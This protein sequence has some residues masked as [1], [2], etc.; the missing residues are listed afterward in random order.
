[1]KT[2]PRKPTPKPDGQVATIS[3]A[4]KALKV[5]RR[6]ISEGDRERLTASVRA[7]WKAAD[8]EIWERGVGSIQKRRAFMLAATMISARRQMATIR[9]IRKHPRVI[10]ECVQL[11]LEAQ[12]LINGYF[13]PKKSGRAK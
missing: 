11:L 13:A 7:I 12:R 5:S 6:P 4:G 3:V 1:M 9:S 10:E 2:K 8:K